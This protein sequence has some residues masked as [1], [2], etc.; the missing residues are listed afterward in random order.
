MAIHTT[1][2]AFVAGKS[3]GHIIPALT[4]AS[5]MKADNADLSILFFTTA[6][7]LD[8]KIMHNAPYINQHIPLQ[9]E[10]LSYNP[11]KL[12]RFMIRFFQAFLRSY[13]LL[14]THQPERIISMGGYISLPVCL[15]AK[16]LRIPI[17]L[18]ELNAVPGKA[19][20]LL[21]YITRTMYICFAEAQ[22]YL[23]A[24]K[25]VITAYPIRFQA[26]H[27]NIS[28]H[29]A[30]TQ[31]KLVHG[32]KTIFISGGSQGSVSINNHIKQW[33]E[34]NA[35]LHALIQIIHQT[36]AQDSTNWAHLYHSYDI[37][38]VVF[39]YKDDLT[40]CYAA[41]DVIIARAGAGSLFETLFFNKPTIIIPLETKSTS[42]QKD[43]AYAMAKAHPQLFTVITEQQIKKDNLKLFK[44]I[45]RHLYIH[46]P[47]PRPIEQKIQ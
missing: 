4:L 15:A 9:L 30:I 39:D 18:Y 44:E 38:A 36:G 19:T 8:K 45:H 25:C 47:Q 5:K 17:H 21:S 7:S 1:S 33:L 42:H 10:G 28:S 3:G 20:K 34:L 12:M 31:L 46:F 22:K 37:P 11:F 32:K 6:H 29:E 26:H 16:A 2:I 43:N 40:V 27:K 35:H 41:T 24:H 23:P 13:S 14:R